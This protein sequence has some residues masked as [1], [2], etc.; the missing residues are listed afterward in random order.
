[1]TWEVVPNAVT[2][3]SISMTAT[4]ASDPSGV[5]YYFGCVDGGCSDSGWQDGVTYLDTG[6]QAG[7]SYSYRVQARDKSANQNDTGFSETA[8]ATTLN[9]CVPASLHVVSIVLGK[10]NAG[11][12]EKRGR[13]EVTV[14][15]DCGALTVGARVDG[16]FT[17]DY[18]NESGWAETDQSGVAV[19]S[20][21]RSVKGKASF[22]FCVTEINGTVLPSPDCESL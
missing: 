12:G 10:E 20:T 14:S 8:S 17:G 13:A 16:D 5:E 3:T 7:T 11:Q 21:V 18:Y 1:M 22:Q 19:I 2:D 15:D 9:A 6:L 4:V